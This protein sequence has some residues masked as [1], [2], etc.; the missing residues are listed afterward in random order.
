MPDLTT[1]YYKFYCLLSKRNPAVSQKNC[2][3]GK[4]APFPKKKLI[5]NKVGIAFF[6]RE[7]DEW[8]VASSINIKLFGT[9]L[10]SWKVPNFF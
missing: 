7:A 8:C 10:D 1:T 5:A 6:A 2:R 3:T 4:G 9:A